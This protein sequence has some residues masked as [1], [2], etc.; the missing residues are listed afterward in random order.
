M[1]LGAI[2]KPAGVRCD[3][4]WGSKRMRIRQIVATG[5]A[6]YT[7]GGETITPASVG[8][9]VIE[10]VSGG[11]FKTSTG[12]NILDWSY[13]F[14]ANKIQYYRY[15]GASVGKA[16]LEEAAANFDASGYTG[17]LTFVGR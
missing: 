13:D 6:N 9:N 12:V 11:P 15:D 16:S 8:L 5:G 7:T 2:T 1:A 3:D 10:N 17:R 4:T 14:A